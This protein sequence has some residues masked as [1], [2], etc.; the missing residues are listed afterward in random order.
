MPYRDYSDEELIIAIKDSTNI[1]QVLR[2]IGLKPAGGNYATIHKR[3]KDLKLDTSHFTGQ[4]WSKGKQFPP[5]Q[6]IE[7]YLL[8]KRPIRSLDLKKRLIRE[9]I[10]EHK[11][12]RCGLT[13]WNNEPIPTELDHIDGNHY[14]NDLSNLTILCPNCHAQTDTYCGK[15]IGKY[16]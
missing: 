6:P 9:G 4:A 8:N 15:N 3:V 11:C 2:K 1:C 16:S 13:T 7:D 5:K 12:Y 10:L 14:N